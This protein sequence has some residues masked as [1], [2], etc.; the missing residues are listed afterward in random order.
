MPKLREREGGTG[1][2][3][4]LLTG[5]VEAEGKCVYAGRRKGSEVFMEAEQTM[6]AKNSESI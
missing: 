5:D 6:E 3:F 4:M 1:L 2:H